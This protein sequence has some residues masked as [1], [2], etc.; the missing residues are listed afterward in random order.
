MSRAPSQ[1]STSDQRMKLVQD[2]TDALA[3]YFGDRPGDFGCHVQAV[4][5]LIKAG[6]LRGYAAGDFFVVK[7]SAG[8]RPAK[9]LRIR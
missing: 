9:G 5:M 1:W 8:R 4:R 6:P 3:E 2:V 7:D